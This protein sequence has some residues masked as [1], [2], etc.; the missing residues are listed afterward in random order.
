MV[1]VKP[2]TALLPD[3]EFFNQLQNNPKPSL[4]INPPEPAGPPASTEGQRHE[5]EMVPHKE[6]SGAVKSARSNCSHKFNETK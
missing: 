6:D 3:S 2:F 4:C 5:E 1:P